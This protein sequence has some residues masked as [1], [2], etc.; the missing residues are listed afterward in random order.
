MK[1]L[2]IVLAAL[3]LAACDL[4]PGGPREDYGACLKSHED[5][6]L[7]PQYMTTCSG[8]PSICTPQ[9]VYFLPV[10][11][12]VCDERQYPKGDGPGYQADLQRYAKELKEW[13]AR[14][15]V[16]RR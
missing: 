6:T 8:S 9:L 2:L 11:S 7:I 12:T 14:H 1:Y 10:T 15:P 13:Y 16:E 3:S 5:T 4:K